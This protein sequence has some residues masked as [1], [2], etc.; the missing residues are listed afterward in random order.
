VSVTTLL[1]TNLVD[2]KLTPE[3]MVSAPRV[4]TEGYAVAQVNHDVPENVID[5]LR[6]SGRQVEYLEPLGGDANAVAIDPH[7]GQMQAGAGKRSVGAVV[8]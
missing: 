5:E 8:F 7:T 4:H 2:F 1:V 6:K 3:Q